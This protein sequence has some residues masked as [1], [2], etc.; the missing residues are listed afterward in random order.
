MKIQIDEMELSRLLFWVSKIKTNEL[1]NVVTD[2]SLKL[3]ARDLEVSVQ[4]YEGVERVYDKL[5]D[6]LLC[7]EE[8]QECLK[9]FMSDDLLKTRLQLSTLQYELVNN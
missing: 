3:D 1:D 6:T 5:S 8:A 9:G 7:I 4:E 2:L